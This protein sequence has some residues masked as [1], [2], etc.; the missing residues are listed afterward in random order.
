MKWNGDRGQWK[1]RKFNFEKFQVTR[2]L[3]YSIE[4]LWKRCWN[5][6]PQHYV[7]DFTGDL[8][9]KNMSNNKDFVHSVGKIQDKARHEKENFDQ[10]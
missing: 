7:W 10:N 6:V 4:N 1:Q 3:K 8:F 5:Y 2:L 9:C